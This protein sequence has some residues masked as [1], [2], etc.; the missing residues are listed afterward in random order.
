MKTKALA[1][2][3]AIAA[4]CGSVVPAAEP[5]HAAHGTPKQLREQM[6][7]AH[8]KMAACLRSDRPLAEC[9]SELMR[10]CQ[11][12]RDG[13]DCGMQ[14]MGRRAFMTDPSQDPD[15]KVPEPPEN[16]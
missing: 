8:E 13:H 14:A 10:A 2:L 1:V 5:A 3:T 9:R 6:A 12:I 11:K 16:H 15:G 7:S 4:S